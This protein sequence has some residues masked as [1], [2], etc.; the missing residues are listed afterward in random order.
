MK[1]RRF[2]SKEE[3]DN[4]VMEMNKNCSNFIESLTGYNSEINSRYITRQI[5]FV[6]S[7]QEQAFETMFSLGYIETTSEQSEQP[8]QNE[9]HKMENV[10]GNWRN[11]C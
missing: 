9:I 3:T 2:Y 5:K 11:F 6:L 8:E 10:V 7:S 4:E 1:S